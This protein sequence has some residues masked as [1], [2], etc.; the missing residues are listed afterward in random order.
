MRLREEK[1]EQQRLHQEDRVRRALERAQAEPKKKVGFFLTRIFLFIS[2][3]NLKKKNG[4]FSCT[5]TEWLFVHFFQIELEFGNVAFW[6]DGGKP[7]Y[8]EKNPSE[9]GR[10]P[11][12]NSTTY[13][14]NSRNRTWATLVGGECSHHC[15]I[16]ALSFVVLW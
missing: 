3:I 4:H 7:E 8:T 1:M 2:F 16:P 14:V 6:V 11:I 10:E 9:Q 15:A 13:G 12:T 5:S